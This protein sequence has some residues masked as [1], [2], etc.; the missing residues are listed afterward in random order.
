MSHRSIVIAIVA[1]LVGAHVAIWI[2][3]APVSIGYAAA[4]SALLAVAGTKFFTTGPTINF[5]TPMAVRRDDLFFLNCVKQGVNPGVIRRAYRWLPSDPRCRLCLFPFRGVGTLLHV[6]P[7]SKNPNFCQSCIESAPFG[8]YEMEVGVLFAD[9]RGYTEWS[10]RH[11]PREAAERMS[12]FYKVANRVFTLDDVIVEF[13]GDQVMVLY[14]PIFPSLAT[15]TPEAMIEAA[16]RFLRAVARRLPGD[17]LEVGIGI[18]MGIASV[19]NV[20]DRYAKDFTALGDVVNTAARL[21]H[22]A[23]G[24]EIVVSETVCEQI[25]NAFPEAVLAEFSVKGKAEPVRARVLR[26]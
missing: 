22:C 12:A 8:V 7:S 20:G 9:V 13:I 23:K 16:E 1:G 26:V 19:G 24:G 2:A 4:G 15:R 21:Q 11:T 17:D 18:H 3:L 5:L 6:K 14:N 10:E 25:G